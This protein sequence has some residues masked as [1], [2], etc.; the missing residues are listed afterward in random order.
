MAPGQV[1]TVSAM[2]PIHRL[3]VR[4]R[5]N[6]GACERIAGHHD[7]GTGGLRQSAGSVLS[8]VWVGTTRVPDGPR[9]SSSACT[10]AWVPPATKPRL[11][12][13]E[14][15]STVSPDPTPSARR[16][17][18]SDRTVYGASWPITGPAERAERAERAEPAARAG[19][20]PPSTQ[21]R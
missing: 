17:E 20:H 8:G 2:T 14:C 4:D 10:T 12:A 1:R 3:G 7:S 5:S 18:A 19:D 21:G 9:T 16:S 11:R 15:I 13:E 6:P